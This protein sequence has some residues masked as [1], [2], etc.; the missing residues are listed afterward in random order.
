MLEP[1]ADEAR[2]G[3][4]LLRAELTA[5]DDFAYLTFEL[6]G[7]V[8]ALTNQAPYEYSMEIS[9]CQEGAQELGVRC[10]DASGRCI[11]YDTCAIRV[12][13]ASLVMGE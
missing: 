4:A 3:R 6:N 9:R 7:A 10:Y 11:A 12:D 8:V 2:E 1:V 13:D 5:G